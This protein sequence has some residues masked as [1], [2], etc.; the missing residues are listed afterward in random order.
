M[1]SIE[2]ATQLGSV[3]RHQIPTLVAA[4]LA[5]LMEPD[6]ETDTAPEEDPLLT[7]DQVAERL[8]VDRKWVYRHKDKLGGMAL[9]RKKL[10][11]PSSGV[12]AY[13]RR[14]K[15]ASSGRRK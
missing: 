6:L 9:S 15:A 10:R 4:L 1:T 11:F 13:L 8:Q 12:D 5:R 2:V 7:A 3:P 14:R